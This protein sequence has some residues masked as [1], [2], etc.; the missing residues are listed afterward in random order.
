MKGKIWRFWIYYLETCQW[1]K[2]SWSSVCLLWEHRLACFQWSAHLRKSRRLH[3]RPI[4]ESWTCIPRIL[5]SSHV[6]KPKC[7]TSVGM[8]S[9]WPIP[10]HLQQRLRSS[11]ITHCLKW[12]QLHIMGMSSWFRETKILQKFWTTSLFL[13]C[14]F[15]IL[16]FCFCIL[17]RSNQALVFHPWEH[18]E[19][20][21]PMFTYNQ[22]FTQLEIQ[23]SKNFLK[24]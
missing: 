4:L 8:P 2:H 19:H 18:E 14:N 11:R 1:W 3:V 13:I 7:S 10:T 5:W 15:T 12:A 22:S 9:Y 20:T 6:Y 24:Y 17:F 16:S 23:I 21:Q